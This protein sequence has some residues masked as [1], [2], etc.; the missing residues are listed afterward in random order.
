MR[1]F[2]VAL[3]ALGAAMSLMAAAANARVLTVGTYHGI[4]GQYKTIQAA[5]DAAKPGTGSW[6][7]PVTTR[8]PRSGRRRALG[9]SP[10]AC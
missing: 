10:P 1:R 4:K 5:V 3:L 9:T 7:A 6:S 8:R 2:T